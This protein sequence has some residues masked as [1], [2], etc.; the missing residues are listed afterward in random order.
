MIAVD[1]HN[2]TKASHALHSVKEMYQAGI[3]AGLQIM[4]FSEHSPRPLGYDYPVEYRDHLIKYFPYYLQ[5]VKAL[6]PSP[7]L[8]ITSKALPPT[9]VLLGIEL[10]WFDEEMAFMESVVSAEKYDYILGGLHFLGKWGFDAQKSDWAGMSDSKYHEICVAY[11]QAMQRMAK[12]G[13]VNIVAHPDLIKIFTKDRFDTWIAQEANQN[14]VR[15]A[16]ESM[17]KHKVSMEISSAGLR[18]PCEEIYPGPI[19]LAMAKECDLSISFASD[20]HCVEHV[21]YKFKELH[22]YAREAGFTEAC[23]YVDRQAHRYTF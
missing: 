9:Q 1:L 18:K 15:E 8:P 5:E 23:Y 6:R 11:Y 21:A 14:I 10:D 22:D 4:G 20:S 3:E 16:L 7:F 2:H 12:S 17:A 13:L 19:I